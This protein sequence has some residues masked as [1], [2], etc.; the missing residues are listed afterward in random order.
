MNEF[1]NT[2]YW[3]TKQ[4]D[5]PEGVFFLHKEQHGKRTK[6]YFVRVYTDARP[7]LPTTIAK[8]K[9]REEAEF[10]YKQHMG[11]VEKVPYY[12][13]TNIKKKGD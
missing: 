10:I 11:N 9:T 5:L 8:C 3:H 7:S 2:N 1:I 12:E 4:G 13:I 6:F